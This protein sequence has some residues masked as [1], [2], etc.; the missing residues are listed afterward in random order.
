MNFIK[1]TTHQPHSHDFMPYLETLI[2]EIPTSAY[3]LGL[4]DMK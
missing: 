3:D 2:T 4:N 1:I